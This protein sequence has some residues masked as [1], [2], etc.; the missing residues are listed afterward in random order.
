MNCPLSFSGQ[1][2][3]TMQKICK[4]TF[5]H[6]EYN[7]SQYDDMKEYTFV[8]HQKCC[9]TV[10]NMAAVPLTAFGVLGIASKAA[11]K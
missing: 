11:T 9:H 4:I 10:N 5:Y 3:V 1:Y 7:G 2:E 6:N 8:D